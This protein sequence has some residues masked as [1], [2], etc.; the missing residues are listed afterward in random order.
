MRD[1]LYQGY[2]NVSTKG[3]IVFF[4]DI[5]AIQVRISALLRDIHFTGMSVTC[6]HNK[7]RLETLVDD[8]YPQATVS[9]PCDVLS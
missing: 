9:R 4:V 7:G 8:C 5:L 2:N 3:V 6:S 1:I